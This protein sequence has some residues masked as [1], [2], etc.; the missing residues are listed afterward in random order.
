[1]ARALHRHHADQEYYIDHTGPIT[2]HNALLL[3]VLAG[4]DATIRGNTTLGHTFQPA[5]GR[6][7]RPAHARGGRG[8]PTTQCRGRRERQGACGAQRLA[9]LG[10]EVTEISIRMRAVGRAIWT[11][12]GV[13]GLTQ[14]M[15]VMASVVATCL[16]S[17]MDFHRSWRARANE[18][19]ETRASL[20]CRL[21]CCADGPSR[22]RICGP[23]WLALGD[24]AAL[25]CIEPYADRRHGPRRG[26]GKAPRCAFADNSAFELRKRGHHLHHHST[27]RVVVSIFSVH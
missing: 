15:T 12:I 26:R 3:E 22:Q 24:F 6:D 10:A 7:Q 27:G 20:H 19:S 4:P 17:L 8:F 1:M 5:G 14:T 2:G 21:M 9:T 18:L 16:T 25:G 23:K 11:P 13:E